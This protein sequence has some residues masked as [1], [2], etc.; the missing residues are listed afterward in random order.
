[1]RAHLVVVVSGAGVEARRAAGCRC[2]CGEATCGTAWWRGGASLDL[3][4]G[5]MFSCFECLPLTVEAASVFIWG[6]HPWRSG[7]AVGYQN[8]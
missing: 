2:Y 3:S 5:I 4:E 7:T 8:P 6:S 1:M